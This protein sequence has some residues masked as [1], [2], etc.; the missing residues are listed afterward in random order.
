M[1]VVTRQLH[2]WHMINE[3]SSQ[4]RTALTTEWWQ[5]FHECTHQDRNRFLEVRGTNAS[6]IIFWI[7]L[8]MTFFGLYTTRS[9]ILQQTKNFDG[10]LALKEIGMAV[11]LVATDRRRAAYEEDS[12]SHAQVYKNVKPPE[13]SIPV[14]GLSA[15][16]LD[17]R[18]QYLL[19]YCE[20]LLELK[21]NDQG[22]EFYK[23]SAPCKSLTNDLVFGKT[24]INGHKS[25]YFGQPLRFSNIE[26]LSESLS[27]RGGKFLPVNLMFTLLKQSEIICISFFFDFQDRIVLSLLHPT[28][29]ISSMNSATCLFGSC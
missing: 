12:E 3:M 19:T 14:C 28:T 25:M 18:N 26:A 16:Q 20:D 24:G 4:G 22:A 2:F 5:G 27:A 23:V 1:T 17:P 21:Q 6:T 8:N 29:W 11:F 15:S 10:A 13:E 7:H 9:V